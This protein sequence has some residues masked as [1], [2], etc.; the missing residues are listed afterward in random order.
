VKNA[1]FVL[2]PEQHDAILTPGN[3]VVRA[4]A[5]SGKTEVLARRFVAL[6]AGDIED[7]EPL[8]PSQV[9]AITFTEKAAYDMRVRIASVLEE[10]ILNQARDARRAHLLRARA[11]LPLARISTIHAFC[12]RILRENAFDAALDPDFQVLDEYESQTFLGRVCTQVLIDKVQQSDPGACYLARARGLD[13]ATP[14][15]GALAIM[16]RIIDEVTRLGRTP[17]WL[18][19]ATHEA[20]ARIENKTSRIEILAKELRR[21]LEELV[22]AQNLGAAAEQTITPLRLRYREVCERILAINASVEPKALD[23][24]REVCEW[25]PAARAP[26]RD[27]VT[28]IKKIVRRERS[29]RFGLDGELISVYGA[30]RAV[31]RAREIVATIRD[32]SASLAA[33]KRDERVVTFD[34]LLLRTRELLE[35]STTSRLRYQTM[36]RAL[37]VDEFQDTDSIQQDILR[38]LVEVEEGGAAPELFVVGDEKQSI[39]RFRGADVAGFGRLRARLTSSGMSELPLRGNRRSSPNVVAFINGLGAKLMRSL[40]RE[41]PA[42]WVEWS[43]E[44][45]LSALRTTALNPAVE[46]IMAIPESPIE[47]ALVA[48]DHLQSPLT[49]AGRPHRLSAGRKRLLEGRAIASRITQLI[50]KELVIDPASSELREVRYGDIVLLLRAF[51]D[52]AIYET[53]LLDAGIPCYTVK[54]RGFFACQ[55]VLDAIELLTAA[56]DPANSLALVAALRSPFFGLSDNCLAELALHCEPQEETGASSPA[57]PFSAIFAASGPEF[58]WLLTERDQ[59]VSAWKILDEL[60][61]LSQRGSIVAVVEHALRAT[62]Y[63][64]VMLGLRQGSQ[65]VANLRKLVNLARDFESRRLFSFHDFVLYLRLLAEQQPYEPP[66]QIL[67]ENDNVVRLM[68]VHQAKGLEF[69]VVFVGDAGRRPDIDTRNPVTD[70]ENGLVLRDAVGSGMD[71]IPNQQL[72]EFRKRS[73]SEQHAESLRLLY[74]ALSRA[75]D[76]LI[77]SEGAMVQGWAKQIRNFVGEEACQTFVISSREQQLLNRADA[78]I[79]LRSPQLAFASDDPI[80][81]PIPAGAEKLGRIAQHRLNFQPPVAREI[82]ISPTAL[83]D[84]G[85]C[86]RQFHFRHRLKL[87]EPSADRSRAE[88]S[89]ATMGT[90]AH[91]VLERLQFGDAGE[92]EIFQLADQL[93]VSAGLGSRERSTIAADLV[94][95]MRNP[96]LNEP[97]AREVPFFHHIGDGLFVRGQIDALLER[98]GRLIVRDYKYAHASDELER[99]QVQMQ[100]YALAIAD[101]YPQARIEAEIVF[102]KDKVSIVP[103]PLPLFPDMRA[104]LLMLG[105]EIVAAHISGDFPKMP[106]NPTICRTLH[107]GFLESCWGERNK[108]YALE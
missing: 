100:A 62:S 64:A 30:C 61:T 99:Y 63:E 36:L 23:F 78:N 79:A 72:S 25:I 27:C 82:V 5:G 71:E 26:I 35:H 77:I 8:T 76:R 15:E 91:A 70:A 21:H 49:S 18:Y 68:T 1:S 57:P 40:E 50:G 39:Y 41:A 58:S 87:P 89:A 52:V 38:R 65:R 66:A 46:I 55:E 3:L 22:T 42:Y 14:R 80:P 48:E 98:G 19:E 96:D 11:M 60:H 6:I 44:H 83:A 54:G 24:L 85:R 101:A 69:P 9:A 17:Q 81:L 33:A 105:R 84:F 43:S 74:V 104:R 32:L 97:A 103:V 67:G 93:G 47:S 90:V 34:D 7:R 45:E 13:S 108:Q 107:C 10:R 88:S 51:T 56:D 12:G 102:L 95:C 86:P 75:R 94:R 4:G 106:S 2:T 53:A 73:S 28:S 20:A 29:S 92:S 16:M 37:L 59:A 31:P